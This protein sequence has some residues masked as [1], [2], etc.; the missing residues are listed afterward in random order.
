MIEAAARDEDDGGPSAGPPRGRNGL[1]VV[2]LLPLAVLVVIALALLVSGAGDWLSLSTVIQRHGELGVLVAE[3]VVAAALAYVAVY[4]AAVALSFPGAGILTILGG[5]LFGWLAG[6]GLTVVAA[7]VGA[8]IIFLVAR[9]SLGD[10]LRAR[11]GGFAARVAE[12]FEADAFSYLLFL[13]LVPIC[14]FWLLN[15]VPALFKVAPRTYVAATALGIIPGTLAY[16]LL[17]SGLGRVV[18]EMEAAHPG[19]AAAG[20]CEIEFAA[21][22]T[23]APLVAM[24]A[25]GLAAVVPLV[26][27]RMRRR[28]A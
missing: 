19:C 24:V 28:T 23:P 1:S 14:P 22:L 26:V 5:Y 7:T 11:A 16:S 2:R 17:G 13:R 9:T 4:I 15:I 12:G 8:T 18:E 6:T 27:K 3:N 10:V 21:L 20:T 25:L